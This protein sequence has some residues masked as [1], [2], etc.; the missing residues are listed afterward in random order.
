MVFKA[1]WRK[2]YFEEI[3]SIPA[4]LFIS[5]MMVDGNRI[6]AWSNAIKSL[7]EFNIEG[8]YVSTIMEFVMDSEISDVA[9]AIDD[10][11]D[12]WMSVNGSNEI[13][14]VKRAK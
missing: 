12:Y 13:Y 1:K 2:K 7:L 3:N 10:D 11:G 4:G 6:I 5:A 9:L 8:N 14:K